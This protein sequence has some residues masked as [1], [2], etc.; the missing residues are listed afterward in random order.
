[1]KKRGLTD[2]GLTKPTDPYPH[3]T[4]EMREHLRAAKLSTCQA[5]FVRWVL[6]NI[7]DKWKESG[8]GKQD[9]MESFMPGL[10][11]L[12]KEAEYAFPDVDMCEFSWEKAMERCRVEAW[13]PSQARTDLA[14]RGGAAGASGDEQ[15]TGAATRPEGSGESGGPGCSRGAAPAEEPQRGAD[16]RGE[17]VPGA[18]RG[19]PEGVSEVDMD[20]E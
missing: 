8:R 11:Q 18:S 12:I 17:R 10:A 19:V 20:L 4:E 7:F 6:R 13:Q 3:V 14:L 5:I 15:P 9:W 16:S 1:M 2:M